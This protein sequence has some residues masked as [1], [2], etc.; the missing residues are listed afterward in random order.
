M[1]IFFIVHGVTIK[2]MLIILKF[3]KLWESK[4]GL[5]TNAES[6]GIHDKATPHEEGETIG[7]ESSIIARLTRNGKLK[8]LN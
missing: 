6:D 2:Q 8:I 7:Q 4:F 5:G 3:P 1:G